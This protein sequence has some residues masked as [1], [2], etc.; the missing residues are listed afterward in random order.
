MLQRARASQ[1]ARTL[2]FSPLAAALRSLLTAAASPDAAW[3]GCCKQAA[4]IDFTFDLLRSCR[5][6]GEIK[7]EE[8]AREEDP[9]EAVQ[10]ASVPREEIARI[11]WCIVG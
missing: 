3:R 11:C 5:E 1:D 6:L 8:D 2:L 7:E 4:G 9:V 10:D